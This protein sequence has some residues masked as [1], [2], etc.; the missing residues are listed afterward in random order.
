[1]RAYLC[2]NLSSILLFAVG[3]SELLVA[4]WGLWVPS[5]G[6]GKADGECLFHV[7]NKAL[8]RKVGLSQG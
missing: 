5:S 4:G 3:S 7:E 2:I 6:C 1:M 8:V